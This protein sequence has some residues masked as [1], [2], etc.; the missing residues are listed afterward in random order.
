MTYLKK[1]TCFFFLSKSGFPIRSDNFSDNAK[2]IS[3]KQWESF[4][5]LAMRSMPMIVHVQL[6][7]IVRHVHMELPLC[8]INKSEIFT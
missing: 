6:N 3:L 4:Q 5:K 2:Y 7:I 1:K 8:L